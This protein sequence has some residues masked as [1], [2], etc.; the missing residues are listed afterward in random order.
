MSMCAVQDLE[1]ERWEQYE[2]AGVIK[3]IP[4]QIGW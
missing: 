3:V 4:A 1:L 2:K